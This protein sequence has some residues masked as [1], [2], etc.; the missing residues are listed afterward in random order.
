[1]NL[2][3][4]LSVLAVF[5]FAFVLAACNKD[6]NETTYTFRTYATGNPSTLN[7]LNYADSA[8]SDQLSLLMGSLYAFEFNETK[9]GYSLNPS[10]AKKDP[11]VIA[12]DDGTFTW[13]I[14]LREDLKWHN[15]EP[16]TADD[17]IY[18][19]K[20]A[21]DPK[22]KMRRANYWYSSTSGLA[23]VNAEKYYK[24]GSMKVCE[25]LPEDADEPK[26]ADECKKLGGTPT[27]WDE[28]E[29]EN[30][31]I[32]KT[33]E[34]SFTITTTRD[35]SVWEF[36]YQLSSFLFA[37]V[38]KPLF[39]A[40]MNDERTETNYGS[41]VETFMGNGPYELIYWENDKEIRLKKSE[42][43]FDKE[44]YHFTHYK[45]TIV[46][47]AD[48]ALLLF[49]NG[50]LDYTS[51]PAS[52]YDDYVNNPIVKT[53]PGETVFRININTLSKEDLAEFTKNEWEYKPILRILEFRQALYF[54]IDR[55]TLATKVMKTAT[56]AQ[57]YFSSAYS[58]NPEKGDIYRETEAAKKVLKDYSP[59]T[60][61]YLRER[62]VELYIEA[63]KKL[64]EAG[65]L[66][67]DGK[68]QIE[69][70][71]FDG[72]THEAVA[73]WLEKQL[74]D[75]FNS[76][77]VK[78]A[79]NDVTFDL[80]PKHYSGLDVY[81]KKQMVGKFDLA[82]GGISGST[83]DPLG[84]LD[85]FQSDNRSGLFLN[86]GFDSSVEDI[87]FDGKK[88]SYDTLLE[89]AINGE[90]AKASTD[91]KLEILALLEKYLIDK[92]ISIPL[93]SNS[94]KVMFSDRVDLYSDEYVPVMG[95]GVGYS[96]LTKPDK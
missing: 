22:L 54:A 39:E 61:G 41:S 31:G 88:W 74:E 10:M 85:V 37:P 29:W 91:K 21:L 25:G 49:E 3:K 94:S 26:N 45:T 93:F 27:Y 35:F 82:L 13:T 9:D 84:Y 11:E 46:K 69:Y 68:I 47:D 8:E 80:V 75:I 57:Y 72:A 78:E 83:L 63:L 34:Y 48:A 23:I 16:I 43:Y 20:M 52:K 1:M 2:K 33:G 32:K 17:F 12:N 53:V 28:E 79:Y 4:L 19:Y 6:N 30:V 7:H 92:Q 60:N 70:A 86:W 71:T 15:G 5:V 58:H 56:P 89:A 42:N 18:T 14:E 24:Q 64:E 90:Y 66:P 38:Y 73:Q 62:A 50:D 87:D 44:K 96:R 55:E 36:K 40:G 67:E 76:E 51:I 77:K 59:E 65:Q 95:F 81:Y